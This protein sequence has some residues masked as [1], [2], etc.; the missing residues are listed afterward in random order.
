M[1]LNNAVVRNVI[2]LM[3]GSVVAQAIPIAISPI[4]T[5]MYTPEDFGVFA[6]FAALATVL[7]SVSTGRYELAIVLP[8]EDQ[9]AYSLSALCL[10]IAAV[11]CSM[12]SIV[13]LIFNYEIALL[14]GN[15]SVAQWLYFIPVVVMLSTLWTVL[16]YLNTRFKNFKEISQSNIIRSLAQAVVQISAGV[17]KT[18]AGGLIFGQIISVFFSNGILIKTIYNFSLIKASVKKNNLSRLAK[19]YSNFPKYNIVAALANSLS[20]NLISVLIAKFFH[21]NHLVIIR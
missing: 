7:C 3:S 16:N 12:L 15:E 8:V 13:L 2:R 14:L 9:D 5:R 17:L 10:I 19:K 1:F 6:V 20:Y 4:L 18:G 21:Y 11:F